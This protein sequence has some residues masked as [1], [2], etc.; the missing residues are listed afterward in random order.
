MQSRSLYNV[1][2]TSRTATEAAKKQGAKRPANERRRE[3]AR[4]RRKAWEERM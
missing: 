3:R 2:S 4:R 1:E